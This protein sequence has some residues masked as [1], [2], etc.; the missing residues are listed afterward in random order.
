MK[1]IILLFVSV[2][3]SLSAYGQIYP[4]NIPVEDDSWSLSED[5]K[6]IE[7]EYELE[8]S[9]TG[10]PKF[11][12]VTLKAYVD[13]KQ[14]KVTALKGDF[15]TSVRPGKSKKIFWEWSRDL[16]E[17]QGNLS[18]KLI[19]DLPDSF[20]ADVNEEATE[21]NINK[22]P[23]LA[24]MG[25][26]A[27]LGGGIFLKGLSDQSSAQSDYQEWLDMSSNRS[28]GREERESQDGYIDANSKHKRGQAF[29][30]GGGVVIVGAAVILIQ[31]LKALKQIEKEYGIQVNPYMEI[32]TNGYTQSEINY[33]FNI[34]YKF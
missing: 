11:F 15:G 34:N 19:Q 20:T 30:I 17:I 21:S 32:P 16:V 31:R 1:T 28:L 33:G 8:G 12:K 29:M 5:E 18:F 7:I 24:G 14:V 13:G 3:F 27:A 23:I 22:T 25:T 6:Y 4:Q 9:P 2:A 26:I 10:L